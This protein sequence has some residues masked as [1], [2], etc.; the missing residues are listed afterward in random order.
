M[1]NTL[2]PI[3][4]LGLVYC[5]T[6][7]TKKLEILPRATIDNQPVRDWHEVK[8]VAAGFVLLGS[9]DGMALLAHYD[10][11]QRRCSVHR[12]SCPMA[13]A[14]GISYVRN[15]HAVVL[16]RRGQDLPLLAVDLTTGALVVHA[17]IKKAAQPI[18]DAT[19]SIDSEPPTHQRA[20]QALLHFL[21]LGSDSQVLE[22]AASLGQLQ[23]INIRKSKYAI[24]GMGVL[25][26]KN[27]GLYWHP[28]VPTKDGNIVLSGGTVQSVHVA[29]STLVVHYSRRDSIPLLAFFRGLDGQFLR[30]IHWRQ[31]F[32]QD[33]FVLANNG[34]MVAYSEHRLSR[35]VVQATDRPQVIF[36]TSGVAAGVRLFTDHGAL[37]VKC[38]RRSWHLVVWSHSQLEVISETASAKSLV[39]DWFR[40]SRIRDFARRSPIEVTKNE[41]F[42]LD[43]AKLWLGA[44]QCDGAIFALDRLGQVYVFDAA[45]K[46]VFQFYARGDSWSAWLPDGTRHGHGQVHQWPNTSGAL[47][48]MASALRKVTG[49]GAQ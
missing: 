3:S 30:E 5:W 49:G 13:S 17:D 43:D 39:S 27:R 16:Y 2:S 23:A 7:A 8:G 31:G 38:G 24:S 21:N 6:L 42:K 19:A 9:Q 25:G 11:S 37:L 4:Y 36:Q 26:V 20:E 1:A 47:K 44:L 32:Q 35:L 33:S 10:L 28:F 34:N 40:N 41:F 12:T 45:H 29:E 46:V 48:A 15:A 22:A 14:N 18:M